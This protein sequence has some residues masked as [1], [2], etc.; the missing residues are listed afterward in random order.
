[1]RTL[2]SV[3]ALAGALCAAD[4][5]PKAAPPPKNLL[6][7]EGVLLL[8]EAGLGERFLLELIENKTS[9]FDTS[10]EALAALARHGLT[11]NVLRALVKKQDH[12]APSAT[13]DNAIALEP[14]LL[15]G[16][17]VRQR[18][19]VPDSA[20]GNVAIMTMAPAKPAPA[21]TPAAPKDAQADRWYL[22]TQR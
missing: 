3:L 12:P 17:I 2:F 7:N 9:R 21:V 22:I 13:A 19:L 1:M 11:E 6:T 8:A 20:G 4:A 10:A 16:K 15:R 18:M 14:H 5:A